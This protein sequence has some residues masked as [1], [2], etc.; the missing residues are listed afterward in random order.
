MLVLRK[1]KISK[2][3]TGI[4]FIQL[5]IIPQIVLGQNS[6]KI[7]STKD[8][9]LL[10]EFN[11]G[12]DTT[13][14]NI[15]NKLSEEFTYVNSDLAIRYA[16]KALELSEQINFRKGLSKSYS[17]LGITYFRISDYSKALSYFRKV[18][19]IS[20]ETKDILVISSSS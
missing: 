11:T 3:L 13:R 16:N 14:V 5:L 8:D 2:A 18:L 1:F 17:N 4:L 9:S 6:T 20:N 7:E 12:E 19:K 15:L 10:K